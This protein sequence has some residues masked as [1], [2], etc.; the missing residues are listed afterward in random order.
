MARKR[1]RASRN[2]WGADAKL[3]D[4]PLHRTT[5]IWGRYR[6]SRRTQILEEHFD[7]ISGEEDWTPRYNIAPTQ[8]VPVISHNLKEPREFS[9]VR[10]GLIPFFL[11]AYLAVL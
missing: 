7:S 9:L 6:L 3:R 8:L 5:I 1:A 4:L 2:H 10:W 11:H